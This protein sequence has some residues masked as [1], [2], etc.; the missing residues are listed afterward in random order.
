MVNSNH[1]AGSGQM[2]YGMYNDGHMYNN[3]YD[4]D[5]AN[6]DDDRNN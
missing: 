4:R 5:H 1:M 3:G 2:G 6:R